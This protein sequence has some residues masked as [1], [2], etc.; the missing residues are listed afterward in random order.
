MRLHHG[1]PCHRVHQFIHQPQPGHRVLRIAHRLAIARRNLRLCELCGKRRPAHQ[2]RDLDARI[3]QVASGDHHLLRALHQQ[4]G[5]SDRIRVMLLVCLDQVLRRHLDAQVYNVIPVVLQNNFD[6]IFP[7]VMHVALHR[8]QHHLAALRRIRLLHELFQVAHRRLH[9]FRRLQYFGHD[10]FVRIE[11]P[12]DFR[13]PCHQWSIYDIQRWRTFPAFPLQIN[14]QP[15]SRALDNVV[16][17]P[18]VQ[19]Q[20]RR[21]CFIFLFRGAEML[22]DRRDVKLIDGR[23]LLFCLLAPVRRNIPQQRGVRIFRWDFLRRMRKKQIL[24]QLSLI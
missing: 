4:P 16:R 19:R 20:I 1:F 12:S 10:Q 8:R 24:R 3:L 14:N 11:K 13:H 2:Q 5:K 9:G 22:G 21:A 6:E 23:T 18:L 7:N 17:Q 15:V